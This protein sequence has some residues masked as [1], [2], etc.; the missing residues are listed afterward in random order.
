MNS[1]EDDDG[2]KQSEAPDIVDVVEESGLDEIVGSNE[3]IEGGEGR[4][5]VIFRDPGS[6]VG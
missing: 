3:P 5:C 2:P 4:G 1:L 6:S